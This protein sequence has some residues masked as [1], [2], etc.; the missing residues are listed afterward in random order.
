MPTIIKS[1]YKLLLGILILVLLPF[2]IPV[3]NLL[4]EIILS[5]GQLVGTF[6]RQIVE[7]RVC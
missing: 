2:I 3:F 4:I 6:A 5:Y 7:N 1:N